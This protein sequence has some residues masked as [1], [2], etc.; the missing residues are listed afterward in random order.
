M[1]LLEFIMI[2]GFGILGGRYF[3]IRNLYNLSIIGLYIIFEDIN[4]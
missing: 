4:N 3:L 1:G 2:G